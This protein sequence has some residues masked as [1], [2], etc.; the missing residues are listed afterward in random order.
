MRLEIKI[1]MKDISMMKNNKNE[2]GSEADPRSDNE[3]DT[4]KCA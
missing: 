3:N 2:D 1:K 4:V